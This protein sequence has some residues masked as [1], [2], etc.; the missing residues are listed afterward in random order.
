MP[1]RAHPQCTPPY[2]DKQIWRY[3][4]FTQFV[5]M[6]ERETLYFN[7]A[8]NFEDPFEGS[9]TEAT[10]ESRT[11]MIED[12][13]PEWETELASNFR[14]LCKERTYLNCWHLN[15][16][17]SAAMWDL[18]LKTNEGIC[19]QSTYEKLK[20]SLQES[21]ATVYVGKVEYINYSKDRIPDRDEETPLG[22]TLSPFLHKRE[23]FEHE[24]ELRA[25][26]Q[27]FPRNEDGEFVIEEEELRKER[28]KNEL[29]AGQYVKV[30]LSELIDTIRVAP[31]APDWI[32]DLLGSVLDTYGLDKE[33]IPSSMESE[34]VY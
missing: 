12:F 19:I 10:S 28:K 3:M 6:L 14:E 32:A 17:E 5:S 16:N 31:S 18:Y 13:S 23:S 8:D 25:I 7:R 15:E 4:D 1:Y 26:I 20:S 11:E 24:S 27:D 34:P 9:I 33:V 22:N 29:P 30:N 2:R 21:E